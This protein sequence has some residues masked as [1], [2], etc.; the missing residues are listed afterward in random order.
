[1]NNK[2]SNTKKANKITAIGLEN[3]SPKLASVTPGTPVILTIKK[4]K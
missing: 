1:M 3:N 2:I 4:K